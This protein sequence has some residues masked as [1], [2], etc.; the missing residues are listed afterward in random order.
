MIHYL[1]V[2]RF[3][4]RVSMDIILLLDL[5]VILNEILGTHIEPIFGPPRPGDVKHSQADISL[6]EACG[7]QARVDF[8]AGLQKTVDWFASQDVVD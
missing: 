8:R 7:Y 3:L 2:M 6:I 5:V 1:Y 4:M